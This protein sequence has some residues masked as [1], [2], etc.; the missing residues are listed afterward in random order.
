[1]ILLSV[2]YGP[3]EPGA[4]TMSMNFGPLNRQG[5]ERRL[6]VAITRATTQ[7]VVFA[8]FDASMI[9]L[10]RTSAEAVRDLKHYL[11]FAD[12]GPVAL[13][14]AIRA[15]G[16]NDY[17]SDF[18]MA[19]AE[20]LRRSGWTVRTQIGVSKYRIDLGV[21]HP[22]APGRFLAGVECDGASYHN[23]PSARDRDRVRHIILEHL[24]WRL[25]RVWSTD[26]FLDQEASIAALDA[27]LRALFEADRHAVAEADH[28]ELPGTETW[29][30]AG[31]E[32]NK[33][34]FDAEEDDPGA[35]LDGGAFDAPEVQGGRRFETAS[36]SSVRWSPPATNV[37]PASGRVAQAPQLPCLET[38]DDALPPPDPTRF[39]DSSYLPRIKAMAAAIIDAEGPIT[40]KRLSDRIARD[41][42]FQRTGKQISSRVWAACQRLRRQVATPDG[43][44]VLA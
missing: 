25:F 38:D 17:D 42:G 24:G 2:G 23:S 40:F 36:A 1:V 39:Y 29:D 10:T 20:Q 14:E 4:K 43:H 16:T 30:G 33:G 27:K 15:V 6:N 44:K 21:V 8:S 31:E 5:G 18:E 34:V 22:D 26:F 13:G 11:D 9:D 19:V 37:L 35:L 32:E 7:V 41:H 3:T 12:R 28:V